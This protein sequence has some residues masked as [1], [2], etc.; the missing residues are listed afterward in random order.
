MRAFSLG[1]FFATI[2]LLAFSPNVRAQN[3]AKPAPEAARVIPDLSG[4]WEAH[5]PVPVTNETALCGIRT[6]CDGLRG[7]N[8]APMGPKLEE[9]EMLPW[10]AE[11]YRAV[12]EGR[13]RDPNFAGCTPQV[14][15]DLMLDNR[16]IFELRQFPDIVFLLYDQD[17]LVRR[18]YLDGRGHP[19]GYAGTWMGH[20]TG[21]YE[22]GALVVDTVGFND[23][24][25]LD[26]VGHPHS[27]ALHL[28]ERIRRISPKAMEYQVTIEDPKAYK[29]PWTR[30]I[31]QDL[32]PPGFQILEGVHC[33]EL[34][35]MGTHYSGKN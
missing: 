25:W 1:W 23:K 33:E 19:D 9:P 15:T 2:A 26:R 4:T 3:A 21:K 13:E 27:D 10:A 30:T 17:H 28:V 5:R 6:V 7:V 24:G 8:T 29:E 35:G 18:I 32:L 14:P 11:K 22:G 31:T 16:R 12:R 34:L 20:S